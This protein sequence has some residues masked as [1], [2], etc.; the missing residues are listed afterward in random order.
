MAGPVAEFG[1]LVV[2]TD[3]DVKVVGTLALWLPTYLAQA[4]RERGLANRFL[5]RPRRESYANTLDTDEFLDHS[6]PAVI[7]TTANTE[8]EPAVDG[9]GVYYADWNVRVS[10][11]VRG[12]TP[13]ETRAHASI[14][15]GCVRRVLVQQSR[16]NPDAPYLPA[17]AAEVDWQGSTVAQVEDATDAG[18]YL[19]VCVNDFVVRTDAVLSSDGPNIDPDQSPYEPPDPE[20]DPDSPYDP[21]AAVVSVTFD[22]EPFGG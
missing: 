1:P 14:Y 21:L 20:N 2:E 13:A 7:V 12:R 18:R 9:N 15:G 22:V 11:V 5:A 6:L 16:L 19:A 3:V 10:S 4:E 17:F 8:A